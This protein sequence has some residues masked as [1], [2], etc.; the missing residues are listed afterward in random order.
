[1][2]FMQE[3]NY[4]NTIV[5]NLVAGP[6]AG[7]STIASGI[8]YKLKMKGVECEQTLEYAKDRVWE[9]SYQTMNDQIYMFGK[10]Y[11]RVWRLNHKV[12]VIISDSPLILSIHYAKFDSKYF[13]DF[14]IEQFN[15]FN[16]ITY[17]IERDTEYNENGRAHTYE[18]ALKADKEL[19]NIL[20]KHNIVYSSVKTTEATDIITNDILQKL[21]N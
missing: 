21:N 19:K 2:V 20:D 1:M 17:F 3:Q 9:G 6:C 14:V 15:K 5:V 10:Q 7:K 18:E 16:N 12:Q 13:E 8:F 11:H 4:E